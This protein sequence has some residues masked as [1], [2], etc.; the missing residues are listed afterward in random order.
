MPPFFKNLQDLN[1]AQP[2]SFLQVLCPEIEFTS[3]GKGGL[4]FKIKLRGTL[5][6]LTAAIQRREVA[7]ELNNAEG[8][9]MEEACLR[10]RQL[11]SGV[12]EKIVFK[13]FV[14]RHASGGVLP[15]LDSPVPKTFLLFERDIAPLGWNIANGASSS[16]AEL[17]HLEGL[18]KREAGEEIM[19]Y[20]PRQETVH[21]LVGAPENQEF[22]LAKELWCQKL[23]AKVGDDVSW[24][25][26]AG[27]DK[28]TVE[29]LDGSRQT[30][31]NL[32]VVL[33]AEDFG[34]ECVRPIALENTQSLIPLDGE[35]LQGHL[36][37]RR[38]GYFS[39]LEKAR[40]GKPSQLFHSGQQQ[41]EICADISNA[42]CPVTAKIL[43]LPCS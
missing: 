20:D 12:S 41:E 36:L 7:Q 25:G 42:L 30:T 19:F 18:I 28:I 23:G 14:L 11:E 2:G 9:A 5:Q 34:I 43:N 3:L 38:I 6:V 17:S 24:S 8:Q 35:I 40:S 1:H 27:P 16:S 39:S 33:N 29:T 15:K 32:C 22:A 21:S 37:D 31:S 13:D 26:E 10:L 4:H